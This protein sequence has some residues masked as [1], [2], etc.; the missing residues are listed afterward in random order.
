VRSAR[1]DPPALASQPL[2]V[3]QMTAGELS[4]DAGTAEASDGLAVETLGGVAL[5]EQGADAG[6][7]PQRPL[8]GC[9]TR[10]LG[11]PL[12]RGLEERG[13]TGPGRRLGQ[14]G[15][16]ERPV[17]HLIALERLPSGV[18][19]GVVATEAVV[20]HR[21]H[22]GRKDDPQ[23]ACGRLAQGGLDQLGRLC[24]PAAPGREHHLGIRNRRVPGRLGDQAIFFDHQR[25][26][27]QLA[28]DKVGRGE[29]VERELQVHERARVASE[30]NLANGQGVPGLEVPQFESD[31]GAGSST[32]EPE[33]TAGFVG[34]DL[35][36]EEQ[37][38]CSG[39]RRHGGCVSLRQPPRE[40]VE[41]DIHHPR[42]IRARGRGA[43]GLGRLPQVAGAVQVAGPQRGA[44]RLEVRLTRG[45]GVEG[46]EASGRAEEQPS[47][48]VD[49]PLVK[50]DL[51]AQVLRLGGPQRV[52]GASLDRDQQCERRVERT[53]VALRPGSR[54]EALG[55]ASR[56]GGQ[57]C[58][59][60][61]ERCRGSQAPTRLRAASRALELLGNVLVVPR[62]G[63]GP[64]PGAAV[65][66]DLWIGGLR[67]GA[68]HVLSLLK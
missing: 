4:S 66:I 30:L 41:Q 11:Q 35:Q 5:A 56:S 3:E 8:G 33:P 55:T 43:C 38:D 42:R 49:T 23:T 58:R 51:P 37:F 29:E 31:D 6:F 1:V 20:E 46:L 61:E 59:A 60:L 24:L 45:A 14:L 63:V 13:I 50:G 21:A 7:D 9:H 19:R 44:E 48:V 57:H 36:S 26:R 25:R 65:G 39:H 53:G 34:T 16:D 32:G 10:A 27:R 18:A 64:V 40:R 62:R 28:G 54:E 12:E 67:Q 15:H 2:A 52:K 22:V 68:V 47:R 17:P